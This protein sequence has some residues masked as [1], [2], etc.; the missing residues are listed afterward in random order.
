MAL[1]G[2]AADARKLV[3]VGRD[4]AGGYFDFYGTK[5]PGK[6]L[7][8]RIAS[9][10]HTY[11]L[12]WYLRPFGASVLLGTF[13][14]D[15]PELYMIDPLGTALVRS[16]PP[17]HTKRYFAAAIGKQKAG[18]ETELEK[19]DFGTITCRQAVLEVAK[20]IYKLHDDIKDKDF[21]LEVSWICEESNREHR[22]I[23]QDLHEEAV[24]AAVAEKERE[25]MDESSDE[26]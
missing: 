2:L 18:A 11:T 15:G 21:E 3:S 17:T 19:I 16:S 8:K 26:E 10:V 12:Y 23:P 22:M 6:V 20:I 13:D 25:D 9:E 1:A 24:K 5:I 7:A 4:E 14:D